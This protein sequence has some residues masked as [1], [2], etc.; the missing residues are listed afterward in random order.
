MTALCGAVGT[1]VGAWIKVFSVD[2]DMF[3]VTFIGQSVV[4]CSQ[5]CA[6]EEV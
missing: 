5:V 4:A 2:P 1:A 3:Y 6:V